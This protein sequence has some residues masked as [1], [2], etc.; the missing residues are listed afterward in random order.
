M[1]IYCHSLEKE[2]ANAGKNFI[3]KFLYGNCKVF[4]QVIGRIKQV[5]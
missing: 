3:K 2:N 5:I 4:K 1:I